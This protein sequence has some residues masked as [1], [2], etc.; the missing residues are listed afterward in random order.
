MRLF[1]SILV[2]I[3]LSCEQSV[4]D[5]KK[6]EKFS[7][8]DLVSMLENMSNVTLLEIDSVA[9]FKYVFKLKVTLPV[10]HENTKGETFEQ[11]VYLSH[12]DESKPMVFYTAGYAIRKNRISELSSMMKSNQI[13]V[14]YRYFGSSKPKSMDFNHLK[15]KQVAYD[16]H[17]V[18]QLFKSVYK[19]KWIG[20]GGSKGGRTA[21]I[22]KRF[23]PEDID[24]T[25]AYASPLNLSPEEPRLNAYFD[26]V[27][28][29]HCQEKVK[30]L[31]RIMLKNRT[32][33]KNRIDGYL[34]QYGLTYNR[35]GKEAVIEYAVLE[36][37]FSFWQYNHSCNEIPDQNASMDDLFGY[38]VSIVPLHIYS[39]WSL[40]EGEA[41]MFQAMT[42]TGYY[43]FVLDHLKDLLAHVK[44]PS[45]IIFAPQ[46]MTLVYN[47]NNM[48]DIHQWVR[49]EGDRMVYI[50]GK[51]DPWTACAVE[52]S[53][54]VD[55]LKI[56]SDGHGHG[57]KLIDL[58]ESDF[59]K[60]KNKFYEWTNIELDRT[61]L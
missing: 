5:S 49:H 8:Y 28:D 16:N 32:E 21:F 27:V 56:I 41:N 6:I 42:E 45:N 36:Y 53:G 44:N 4:A 50:Y 60:V 15:I 3:F 7:K 61:K 48:Q 33:L 14:E 24:A 52:L 18:V 17:V 55:A 47:S 11:L 25:I 23:F 59:I 43:G 46:N 39:D 38:L 31:Q 29:Q 34:P 9:H 19:G 2:F 35:I 30:S 13:Y 37:M 22:H 12:V 51:N 20:T 58:T 10:D 40:K 57:V 26:N 1:I 54:G